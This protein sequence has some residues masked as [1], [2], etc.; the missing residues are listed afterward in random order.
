LAEV[1][2]PVWLQIAV[3]FLEKTVGRCPRLVKQHG[4]S[5]VVFVDAVNLWFVHLHIKYRYPLRT[6]GR[7]VSKVSPG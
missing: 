7:W 4:D 1:A 6:E 5:V 2:P 3:A